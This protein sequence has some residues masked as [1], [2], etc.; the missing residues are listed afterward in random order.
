MPTR[1]V[2]FLYAGGVSG[3]THLFSRFLYFAIQGL[4]V[5]FRGFK[6]KASESRALEAYRA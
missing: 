4:Q 5:D 3:M 1:T 6:Y 2:F